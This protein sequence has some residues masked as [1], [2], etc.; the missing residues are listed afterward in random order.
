MLRYLHANTASLF[1]VC[2]YLHVARGLYYGSYKA[3]RTMP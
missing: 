2:I 3:P 1:F